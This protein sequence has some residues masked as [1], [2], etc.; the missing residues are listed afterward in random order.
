MFKSELDTRTFWIAIGTVFL[1]G[2][3]LRVVS[4]DLLPADDPDSHVT[5]WDPVGF[6]PYLENDERIYIALTEQLEAGRG[7]T[8]QGN[9]ILLEPWIATE[10]YDRRLFQHPPGGV[11]LFYLT[12]RIF[13]NTGYA[14]AQVLSFGIF[15][16]SV[17]L[18]IWSVLLP[19][20]RIAALAAMI[21]ASVTPILGHVAGRFWLDGPLL[22]FSTA[23]AAVFLL[24][25]RRWSTPLVC[26]AA[27]LLGYASLI[28][29][30]AFLIAPGVAALAW[31]ITPRARYRNLT[32]L[33]MI[34]VAIAVLI[35]LPWEIWQWSVLGSFFP[36]WANKPGQELVMTNPY[37]HYTVMRSPWIYLELLPQVIWTLTPS[38]VLLAMQWRDHE[39]RKRGLAL[40]FWIA[41][42]VGLN[43]LAG[44]LGFAKILRYVILVTPAT[45]VLF[46]L[47]VGGIL[48]AIRQGTWLPGGKSVTRAVLLLAVAG[49]GLEITQGLKTSLVDN[50]AFDLIIPLPGLPDLDQEFNGPGVAV[51][52]PDPA[53]N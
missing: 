44:S 37:V 39:L 21:L 11:A 24:G 46:A 13:G 33:T 51:P 29:L 41:L 42:I 6:A 14:L 5:R 18:L 49:L 1:L 7:Y 52:V 35:Q 28:K 9:P 8:L 43:T 34:F 22:A 26:L 10:Q 3:I 50:P 45:V 27:V 32:S 36:I 15:F 12:H 30:T 20:N 16:W 25:I 23:A 48:E 31:A 38:L 47:V 17:L 4:M 40:V 2:M 53:G 19:F